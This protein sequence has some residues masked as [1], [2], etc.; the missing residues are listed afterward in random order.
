[1]V[2][3]E[4]PFPDFYY[5]SLSPSVAEPPFDAPEEQERV[6]GRMWGSFDEVGPL[7]V[8]LVRSPGKEWERVRADCWN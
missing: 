8:A 3:G 2:Q 7:R 6:W 4:D 5:L 1:M